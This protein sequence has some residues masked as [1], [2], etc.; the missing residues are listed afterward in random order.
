MPVEEMIREPEGELSFDEQRPERHGTAVSLPNTL[1]THA[2]RG[3]TS[4][5]TLRLT[6]DY[7]AYGVNLKT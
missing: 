4:L 6:A 1:I 2:H 5:R 7:L 3:M